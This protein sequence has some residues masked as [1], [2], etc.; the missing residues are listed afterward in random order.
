MRLIYLVH[1]HGPNKLL[2]SMK[3]LTEASRAL[4][5]SGFLELFQRHGISDLFSALHYSLFLVLLFPALQGSSK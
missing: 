3:W 1:G 4:W 2:R 5:F